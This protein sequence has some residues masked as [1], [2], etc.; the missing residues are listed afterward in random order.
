MTHVLVVEDNADLA[1]GLRATLEF[2]GYR[3]SVAENGEDG[4]REALESDPDLILLDLML[5]ELSGYEVLRRLRPN[6]R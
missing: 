3:V 6:D 2:E 4:L 1:F 5:P